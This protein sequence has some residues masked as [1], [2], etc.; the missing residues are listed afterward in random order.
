MLLTILSK[1]DDTRLLKAT[2]G[3]CTGVYHCTIT[4]RS[5]EELQ[6]VVLNE[7]GAEYH[8]TVWDGWAV[9]SCPDSRHRAAV[10]KHAIALVLYAIR[11]PENPSQEEAEQASS[12]AGPGVGRSLIL[13]SMMSSKL[14]RSLFRLGRSIC[15]FMLRAR[16]FA[17]TGHELR[18]KWLPFVLC[19]PRKADR[20]SSPASLS[21]LVR[22][23]RP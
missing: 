22:R 14:G 18:R 11:H 16:R 7:Q 2:Q 21:I 15:L 9:C 6:G 4:R 13:S 17:G 20:A 1:A 23:K 3:L 10:C 19:K 8:V 12:A 5:E